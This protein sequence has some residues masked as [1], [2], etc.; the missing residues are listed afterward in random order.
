MGS[1]HVCSSCPHA[2]LRSVV[3]PNPFINSISD[4]P[5]SHTSTCPTLEQ[6]CARAIVRMLAASGKVWS[7]LGSG[8]W[9][10]PIYLV[11]LE[12]PHDTPMTVVS[13]VEAKSSRSV[14]Y[15]KGRA[16]LAASTKPGPSPQLD[17][18][19]FNKLARYGT[20]RR[21][22]RFVANPA[23]NMQASLAR[24]CQ[25]LHDPS[26]RGCYH[27]RHRRRPAAASHA[28]LL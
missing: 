19:N 9:L 14:L 16:A 6:Q 13:L 20:Q 8:F 5:H 17:H 28:S 22:R 2:P 12:F 10:G 11:G 1:A 15:A 26:Y 21:H 7:T 3:L 4:I 18:D 27:R 25:A 23:S 24:C